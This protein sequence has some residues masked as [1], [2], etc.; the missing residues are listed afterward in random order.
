[1]QRKY[2][3]TL[4]SFHKC[5]SNKAVLSVCVRL[6]FLQCH[7]GHFRITG[8]FSVSSNNATAGLKWQR[9]HD[10]LSCQ[11]KRGCHNLSDSSFV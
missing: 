7:S 1:M 4:E 5:H 9:S 11:D 2:D 10:K 6:C 3:F 8:L